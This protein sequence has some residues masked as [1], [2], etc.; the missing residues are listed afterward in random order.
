MNTLLLVLK[1]ICLFI[2]TNIVISG[3]SLIVLVAF[4]DIICDD[5]NFVFTFLIGSITGTINVY[6]TYLIMRN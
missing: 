2:L 4:Y 1:V 6:I 3:F 5:N